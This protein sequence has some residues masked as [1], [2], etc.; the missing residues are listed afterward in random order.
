[1]NLIDEVLAAQDSGGRSEQDDIVD[2]GESEYRGQ[3]TTRYRADQGNFFLRLP[4]E[5]CAVLH[6]PTTVEQIAVWLATEIAR[7]T[8]RATRVQAFEGIDKG[9]FAQ[10]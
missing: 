5:R 8:G 7:E 2:G 3:L 10:A 1:M 4:R 6:T 9:A